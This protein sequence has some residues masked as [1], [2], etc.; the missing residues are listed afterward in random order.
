MIHSLFFLNWRNFAK[1]RNLKIENKKSSDFGVFPIARS[2]KK[3][4][5]NCH[6][7]CTWFL[8]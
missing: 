1:K 8:M 6:I 5:I 7:F 3:N 2:E 4:S